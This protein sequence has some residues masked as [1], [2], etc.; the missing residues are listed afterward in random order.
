M[1]EPHAFLSYTRIDDRFHGGAITALRE[2][3]ELGVQV[4][5]GSA[6]KIFQDIEGIAF[7]RH[8]PSRLDEAL[9]QAR[10]LIPII[11]PTFFVRP[12]CRDELTKFLAYERAAGRNDRILPIYF[13]T[14]RD[15]ERRKAGD[16]LVREISERQWESWIAYADLAIGDPQLRPAIRRVAERIAE[17][18]DEA[19]T[20]FA[21][22]PP[23]KAPRLPPSPRPPAAAAPSQQDARPAN[24]VPLTPRTVFRDIDAPW[25]PEMV[26]VPA[27]RFM[28]GSAEGEA[29]SYGDE[30]PRHEVTIARPFALG[31]YP[32]TFAEYDRFCEATGRKRPGDEGWGRGR[33][34]VINVSWED[35]TAYC[36]WL[37]QETGKTYR[38]PS[39]AEWEYA[40]RAGTSTA[41]W[42][43]D[44]IGKGNANCDGC[45]S[46]WDN[47]QTAPVGSFEAKIVPLLVV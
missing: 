23:P 16:E 22:A 43:G 2:Q 39:E 14:I 12:A 41:Y 17:R 37:S 45:G 42:W 28:M 47:K 5:S 26:V 10:F 25:C 9:R 32:V 35:A 34:P 46:Q 18:I 8:W 20:A 44:D 30:R 27:G 40:C 6:F 36:A 1:A 33:R 13:V 21:A 11:T 4:V 3:L 7:G 19:I 24:K 38:L 15:L 31:R 29:R